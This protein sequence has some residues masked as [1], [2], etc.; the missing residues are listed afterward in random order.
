MLK[1]WLGSSS[2]KLKK[3]CSERTCFLKNS[4]DAGIGHFYLSYQGVVFHHVA[5]ALFDVALCAYLDLNLQIFHSM[6]LFKRFL[7]CQRSCRNQ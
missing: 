1:S 3:Q 6:D 5:N 4:D 7:T 2:E